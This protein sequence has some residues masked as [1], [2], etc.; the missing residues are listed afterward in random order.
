[1]DDAGTSYD[2]DLGIEQ[3]FENGAE[4][5]LRVMMPTP[6]VPH[7]IHYPKAQPE[8]MPAYI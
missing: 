3:V 7:L 2:S 5:S 8:R 4:K 1:M 6:W